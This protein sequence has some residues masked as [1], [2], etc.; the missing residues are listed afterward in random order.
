MLNSSVILSALNSS[1]DYSASI[2]SE[3]EQAARLTVEDDYEGQMEDSEVRCLVIE[4][5]QCWTRVL[6]TG[7]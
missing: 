4:A 2:S 5:V 7:E 6:R 1:L 3:M